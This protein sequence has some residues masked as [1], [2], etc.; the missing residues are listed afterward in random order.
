MCLSIRGLAV[1]LVLAAG[2]ACGR[3]P[4]DGAVALA[5]EPLATF[6]R[7]PAGAGHGSL[8][9]PA[10]LRLAPDGFVFTLETG[11]PG[12]VGFRRGSAQPRVVG[13]PGRGPGEVAGPVDMDVSPSGRVWVA[14]QGNAKLVAYQ[15]GAVWKEWLVDHAPMRV[16]AVGDSQ[17]WVG[18]D[19]RSSILVRYD[20]EGRRL[21]TAG[22][23]PD[24]T[25]RGFRLN[26]GSAARGAGPCA[27][28][29]AFR[30]H[31][32]VDCYGPDG[33]TVWSVRGP[34]R[35]GPDRRTNP[36]RMQE[37]DRFAYTD[38]AVHGGRVY[39]L[40]MGGPVGQT[41]LRTDRAHVFDVGDG[42]FLGTLRLPSPA[43]ALARSDSLLAL[44]EYEPEPHILLYRIR[45]ER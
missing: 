14:D 1:L 16:V 35:I 12:A 17:V 7:S 19:L 31:S 45:E 6:G 28:V 40:F 44:L 25:L 27:V 9:L 23:P 39:A 43:K 30:F 18:G 41:A 32:R 8:Q 24:T 37:S 2:T 21:G 15:D 4:R 33:R 5:A 3:E 10:H 34:V 36:Y 11:H 29:W 22:V 13:R 20:A 26:Q 42:R 38:L